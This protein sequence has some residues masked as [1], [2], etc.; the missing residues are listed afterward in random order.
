MRALAGAAGLLLI[1][2]ILWDAF[3]T[4]VLPRR[5]TRRFRLAVLYFETMWGVW[6]GIARAIRSPRRRESFLSL[7]GPLSLVVLLATWAASLA[8]GFALVYVAAGLPASPVGGSPS[9]P[10][11][12]FGTALYFSG[13]TIF[14]LGLGDVI[15]HTWLTRALTAIEAFTGFAFLALVISY[16]PVIYQAFSRREAHIA[17]L[18]EWAGSPP[19]AGELLRRLGRW[20]DL[21]VLDGFFSTWEQWAAELMESHIS[22]P[23]LAGFRSQHGNE[24]WLAALTM[25]LDASALVL[26][27]VG[28]VRP[29]Q[30]S[31]AFAMARHVA[32]DLCQVLDTPPQPPSRDRLPPDEFRRLR[33]V[34]SEAGVTL[35]DGEDVEQRLAELRQSYEPYVSALGTALLLALPAWLPRDGAKDNWQKT[36]WH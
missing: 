4:V 5:V 20:D 24:S 21:S 32:V 36:A 11:A 19:S 8:V 12:A 7:F 3:E 31:M 2:V 13:S 16:L 35:R 14:T 34:L 30:A 22:Y 23:I 18:D 33:V 1:G 10:M 9:S 6:F 25:V 29:R 15:P 27:G 26:T 17:M 28:G